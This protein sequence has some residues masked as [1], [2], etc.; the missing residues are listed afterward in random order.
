MIDLDT[1]CLTEE[2]WEEMPLRDKFGFELNECI[3]PAQDTIHNAMNLVELHY[4]A[5]DYTEKEKNKIID[6]LQKAWDIL[7]DP[8]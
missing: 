4:R 7:Q 8:F 5:Y 1:Y 3:I 6:N 2:Q